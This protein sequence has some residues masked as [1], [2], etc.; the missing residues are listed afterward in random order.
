MGSTLIVGYGTLLLRESMGR[1]LGEEASRDR[2]LV[3]VIV[4]GY[5]RLYNLAPAHYQPAF[6]LRDD[7]VER[8]AANVERNG[9]CR[10]N[11]LAFE[12]SAEEVEGLDRR[13]K[14]YERVRVPLLHFEGGERMGE[15]EMY[16]FP[17]DADRIERDPANLLPHWRDILYARA[18][19]WRVSDRFGAMFDETTYLA[20]GDTLVVS[21]YRDHLD[22]LRETDGLSW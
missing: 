21:F 7:P 4:E 3:P 18:G 15:G 17:A 22:R 14:D 12:A 1:T 10:F 8:A 13:E 9:A 11:G 6:R 20:D 19:A 2:P 5:K 16:V